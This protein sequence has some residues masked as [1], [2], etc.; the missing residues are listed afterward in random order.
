MTTLY[1]GTGRAKSEIIAGA[2]AKDGMG[3]DMERTPEE[4]ANG[5]RELNQMM[6]EEPF[7]LLGYALP[8]HGDGDLSD[9]SGLADKYIPAIIMELAFRLAPN[10]GKSMSVE[11]VKRHAK[12]M[13]TLR[14]DI[15]A[16][17]NLSI[18]SGTYLG[19]GHRTWAGRGTSYA[20]PD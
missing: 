20:V 13:A 19:M 5:L 6:M 14:G 12:A 3:D 9:L 7:S 18:R 4:M 8:A 1:V 11:A 2:Y 10:I 15:A 16:A 17:P